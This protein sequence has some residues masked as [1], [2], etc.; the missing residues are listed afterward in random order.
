MAGLIVTKFGVLLET[1]KRYIYHRSWV[2]YI[3]T[4]V[5]AHAQRYPNVSYL[6]NDWTDCAEIWR[7]VRGLLA[8]HLIQAR[9]WVH[10]R[11]CMCARTYLFSYFGNGWTDCAEI[12]YVIS[13]RTY[14]RAPFPY[15]ESGWQ[16]CAEIYFGGGGTH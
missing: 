12:W 6:G 3:C 8:R 13:A 15:L 5:R 14:I 9:G 2:V 16:H 7:V 1:M 10:L 4:C 11:F